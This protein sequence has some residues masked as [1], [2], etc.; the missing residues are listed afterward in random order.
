MAKTALDLTPKEWQ[1]YQLSKVL[2]RRAK[3]TAPVVET[4]RRLAWDLAKHAAKLLRDE[5]GAKKVFVFG[6]LAYEQGYSPWSD[7]DLAVLGI[8]AKH[9]YSAV[10]AVTS[11]SSSFKLDLV[12]LDDCRSS[13][14]K[15]IEEEGCEI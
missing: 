1:S 10:A 11:L 2:E 15:A 8:P 4:R 6:S 12:D 9:F 5:F 13:L 3:Q 7:I 14:K